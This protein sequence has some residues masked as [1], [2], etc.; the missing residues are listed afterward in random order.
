MNAQM[1]HAIAPQPPAPPNYSAS[2][3]ARSPCEGL[4]VREVPTQTASM[5]AL[6]I[7]TVLNRG[8][9]RISLVAEET[10]G[11]TAPIM[12]FDDLDEA[13]AIANGTPYGLSC[14]ICSDAAPSFSRLCAELHAGSVSPLE[15]PGYRTEHS[16]FGVSNDSGFGHNKEV[17]QAMKSFTNVKSGSTP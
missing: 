4:L 16:S 2:L 7:L 14:R 3:H 17:H 9:P 11:P 15:V 1:I 13:I 5:G 6:Y 8:R 12:T 10:S